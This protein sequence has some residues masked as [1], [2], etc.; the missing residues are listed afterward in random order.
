MGVGSD[1]LRGVSVA[2][3]YGINR[4]GLSFW[5][6]GT[7]P[8]T[9]PS[10]CSCALLHYRTKGKSLTDCLLLEE[11]D[12]ISDTVHYQPSTRGTTESILQ[13]ENPAPAHLVLPQLWCDSV[14]QFTA[15]TSNAASCPQL[16]P[17]GRAAPWLSSSEAG[18]TH[19][20]LQ[21]GGLSLSLLF[22]LFVPR[23]SELC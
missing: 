15:E 1:R 5:L 9:A 16:L 3:A 7:W 18:R 21:R 23:C 12:P 14:P 11:Q 13:R 20:L 8:L 17:P 4:Q 2:T 22:P 19:Y 6:K 10:S